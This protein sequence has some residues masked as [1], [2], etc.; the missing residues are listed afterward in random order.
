[1][2]S[3]VIIFLSFF[4]GSQGRKVASSSV[5][6]PGPHPSRD[7]G[8]RCCVRNCA[9]GATGSKACAG[10]RA[11]GRGEAWSAASRTAHRL[12]GVLCRSDTSAEVLKGRLGAYYLSHQALQ[13]LSTG[14]FTCTP[15][16]QPCSWRLHVLTSC[17]Y[18][19]FQIKQVAD[20]SN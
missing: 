10:R 17:F 16:P 12:R 9:R 8:R 13:T 20:H 4:Q 19:C 2:Q 3:H 14:D 7:R 15:L 18:H 1:M 11:A 6:H 5:K